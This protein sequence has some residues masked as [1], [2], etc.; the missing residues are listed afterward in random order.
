MLRDLHLHLFY[1]GTSLSLIDCVSLRDFAGCWVELDDFANL[2]D[3]IPSHEFVPMHF[4]LVLGLGFLAVAEG[5][6]WM[7]VCPARIHTPK[8][9]AFTLCPLLWV[10]STILLG[11][12]FEAL[13]LS[14]VA[15]M[16]LC[17]HKYKRKMGRSVHETEAPLPSSQ[18]FSGF[19]Q[20]TAVPHSF[21]RHAECRAVLAPP[22]P[23]IGP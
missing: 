2:I 13:P 4:A 6:C 22:S 5:E 8:T 12:A 23:S 18:L 19:G 21:P 16:Q 15:C 1:V 20:G 11:C 10:L 14:S 3:A 7:W 17:M 9:L